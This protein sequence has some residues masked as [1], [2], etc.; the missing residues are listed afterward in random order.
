M[1]K[2]YYNDSWLAKLLLAFTSCH[3]IALGPFV[4][5][6]KKE[7]SQAYKNHETIHAMQWTEITIVTCIVVL[8]LDVLLDNSPYWYFLSFV[9]YYIIYVVEWIVKTIIYLNGKK[10]YRSI[11][12]EREAYINEDDNNYIENRHIF[13]GWLKKICCK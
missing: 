2:R 9:M 5:S 3:T 1:M 10:A 12:F 13:C 4:L 6:K 8:A 7:L 11:G